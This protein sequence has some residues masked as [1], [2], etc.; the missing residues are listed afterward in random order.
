M[1]E[2]GI[3]ELPRKAYNYCNINVTIIEVKAFSQPPTHKIA[4]IRN[5]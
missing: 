5:Y 1:Q 4:I 2:G 3:T